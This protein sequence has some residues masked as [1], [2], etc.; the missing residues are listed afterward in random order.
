MPESETAG[1]VP[2]ALLFRVSVPERVPRAVGAKTMLTVQEAPDVR[3]AGQLLDCEKSPETTKPLIDRVAEPVLVSVTV[4]ALLVVPT[5]WEA[6]VLE[7]GLN[8]ALR[9]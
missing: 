2:G 6:K 4:C 8:A 9:V 5:R 3:L 7:V 1:G